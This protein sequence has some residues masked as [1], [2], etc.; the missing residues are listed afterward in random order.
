[1]I[2]LTKS[3]HR[4][5]APRLVFL[6]GTTAEDGTQN[7]IPITN[8]TS[9]SVDP[10]QVLV[11]V[12]KE[13]QT[14]TNLKAAQGF[15][16]SLAT[17]DQLELVWKLGAKYSGYR[18]DQPKIIE[19]KDKLDMEFS[20]YGP[21]LKDA[22]S[23]MECK[24]VS[25]PDSSQGDHLMVVGECKRAMVNDQYSTPEGM[26]IG[27]PK[28]LMQWERNQFSAAEDI[29]SIEYFNDPGF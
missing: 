13:W 18:S 17:K 6:V 28:P 27:N 14:C 16:L 22:L 10:C 9:V 25:R 5:M 7:I 8:V 24:I 26:P 23:W 3:P 19:F 1:M 20:P 2:P 4:L 21:V 12:Y 15:T 29:F 11:A